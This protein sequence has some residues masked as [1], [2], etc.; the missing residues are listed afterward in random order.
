M[1]TVPLNNSDKVVLVSDDKYDLAMRS[2]WYLNRTGYPTN[3]VMEMHV[4]LF[5]RAPNGGE[6][7]HKDLDPL[8]MQNENVRAATRTLNNANKR[9][10]AGRRTSR[11]KG[12]CWQKTKNKWQAEIKKDYKKIFLGRY[13][14]EEDAAR[15][16]DRAAIECFGEYARL[17]F[18]R[19]DYVL[20]N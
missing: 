11:F 7:D 19:S 14:N 1:K 18:P 16:Y 20:N 12:V 2:N 6:W 4:F 17:N 15:A 13:D 8:N 5:G 3:G 10:I 9:K